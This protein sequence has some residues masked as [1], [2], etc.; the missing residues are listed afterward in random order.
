MTILWKRKILLDMILG[1]ADLILLAI[2]PDYA[3]EDGKR[4]DN[5]SGMKYTVVE[6]NN[7]DKF[8]VKIKGQLKPLMEQEELEAHQENGEQ[9]F[10]RFIN[11]V[12]KLYV[13]NS[14]NVQTLEDSFSADGIELVK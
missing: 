10:V 5:V 8:T 6:T 11:C 14:G 3:Y 2:A 12:D 7:F 4:T 1:N 13:K 9:V